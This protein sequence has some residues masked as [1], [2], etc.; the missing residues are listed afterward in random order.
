MLVHVS[1]KKM[2]LQRHTTYYFKPHRINNGMALKY[3]NRGKKK[4]VV[5]T[6]FCKKFFG[7]GGGGGGRV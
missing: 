3:L 2:W 7:G 4:V 1:S 6:K 5:I